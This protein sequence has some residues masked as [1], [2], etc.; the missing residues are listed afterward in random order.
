MFSI[1]PS[2]TNNISLENLITTLKNNEIVAGIVVAGSKGRNELKPESDYD[3]V[4]I[5]QN[6]PH[7]MH[8]LLTTIEGRMSDIAFWSVEQLDHMLKMDKVE[9]NI[10]ESTVFNWIYTGN[11]EYDPGGKLA[12]IKSHKPDFLIGDNPREQFRLWYQINFNLYHGERMLKSDDEVYLMAMDFRFLYMLLE[13]LDAYMINRGI[14]QRGEKHTIRYLKEHSPEH[15]KLY[16]AA[17]QASNRQEKFK[18]Y[19]QFAEIALEPVG[20]LWA[21]HQVTAFNL[22]QEMPLDNHGELFEFWR[23]LLIQ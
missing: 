2:I 23:E 12:A 20:G 14:P 1:P 13:V 22:H 16:L 10:A 19:K 5:L 18:F 6:Y 4:L 3:I 15:L 9:G 8:V 11:I 17:L 7:P 21:N